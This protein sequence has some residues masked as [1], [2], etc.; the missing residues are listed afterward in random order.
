M[1]R[2]AVVKSISQLPGWVLL[3]LL[4]PAQTLAG[5]WLGPEAGA[6]APAAP[7]NLEQ[8]L[9]EDP[10]ALGDNIKALPLG[11][12]ARAAHVLVQVRD[13]EPLHYHADSD[14]TVL[15]LRGRGAIQ[16]GA[17]SFP[18]TAGDAIHIP[19][20]VGHAYINA[21]PEIGVALVVYSPPPG[22]KDRVLVEDKKK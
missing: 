3:C 14:I 19:R 15:M 18:V 22:P 8:L 9:A 16:I 2:G 11:R 13:R 4:F 17:K 10:L 21:G 1:L 5:Q 20:G 12:S 6:T 7:K